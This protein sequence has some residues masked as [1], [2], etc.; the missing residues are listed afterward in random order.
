MFAGMVKCVVEIKFPAPFS[1]VG[2]AD[3]KGYVGCARL[4]LKADEYQPNF[5]HSRHS[6]E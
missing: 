1:T 4:K 2:S 3:E 5:V 6:D